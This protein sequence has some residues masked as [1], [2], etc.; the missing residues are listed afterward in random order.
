MKKLTSFHPKQKSLH[1]KAASAS[2][3]DEFLMSGSM[4]FKG[5]HHFQPSMAESMDDAMILLD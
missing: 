1:P 3:M 2:N 5:I 4:E